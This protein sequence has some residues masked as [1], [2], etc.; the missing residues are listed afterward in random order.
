MRGPAIIV[1][2]LTLA[3]DDTGFV[4]TIGYPQFEGQE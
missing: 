3:C 4:M 2:G 1:C